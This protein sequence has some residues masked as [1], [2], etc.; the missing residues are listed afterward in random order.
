MPWLA[1]KSLGRRD[2][3]IFSLGGPGLGDGVAPGGRGALLIGILRQFW[4]F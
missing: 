2:L 1:E 3:T 4:W